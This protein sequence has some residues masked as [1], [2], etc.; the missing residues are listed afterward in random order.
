MNTLN[1][2]ETEIEGFDHLTPSLKESLGSLKCGAEVN[3][4]GSSQVTLSI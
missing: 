3:K 2:I 1:S 4:S